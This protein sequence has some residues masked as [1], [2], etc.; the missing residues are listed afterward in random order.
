MSGE[1][2]VGGDPGISGEGLA[3]MFSRVGFI[4]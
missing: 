4:S 2:K 3:S 1:E